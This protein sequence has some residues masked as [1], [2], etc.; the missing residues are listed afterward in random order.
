MCFSQRAK[1]LR[2]LL[3]GVERQRMELVIRSHRII[4]LADDGSLDALY[5]GRQQVEANGMSKVADTTE[6]MQR[7]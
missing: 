5:G 3:H 7:F 4:S 6:V 1:Q 2:Q